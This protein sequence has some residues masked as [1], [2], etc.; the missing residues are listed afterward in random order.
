[1]AE[2]SG[3]F[4]LLK[5]PLGRLVLLTIAL[6][7]LVLLAIVA[8]LWILSHTPE[9]V[10]WEIGLIFLIVIETLFGV[11]A[12]FSLLGALV[13][14][15]LVLGRIR[16]RAPGLGVVARGLLL[17]IS[18]LAALA[19]AEA[20]SVLWQSWS[21]RH[22]ALPTGGLHGTTGLA[23]EVPLSQ[24]PAVDQ[25]PNDFPDARDDRQIDI[26]VLGESSAAGVPYQNWLSVGS[27]IEWKLKEIF[28]AR[29]VGLEILA[30][31]CETLESQQQKLRL[32]RTSSRDHDHLLRP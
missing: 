31:A 13:C 3:V 17:A 5:T 24:L 18:I 7:P 8:T 21:H 16:Q 15:V 30:M 25:L 11:A 29:G 10:F 27:I 26:L 12:G 4:W 9:W 32:I 14:G 22:T 20:A 23:D 2:R 28:P 6:A 1:M 19:M